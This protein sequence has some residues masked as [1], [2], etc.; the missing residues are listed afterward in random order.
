MLRWDNDLWGDE[1]KGLNLGEWEA[2]LLGTW[3][4][5]FIP[6][7]ICFIDGGLDEKEKKNYEV[8]V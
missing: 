6:G 3:C 2:F 5:R 7:E 8:K 1:E 4:P